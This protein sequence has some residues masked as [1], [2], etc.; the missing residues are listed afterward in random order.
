M[1][2]PSQ[3]RRWVHLSRW[4]TGVIGKECGDS[5]GL[6][7]W[8][9]D[10]CSSSSSCQGSMVNPYGEDSSSLRKALSVGVL[11]LTSSFVWIIISF[12]N[13]FFPF[14]GEDYRTVVSGRYFM[15]LLCTPS[16][17]A[18]WHLW[19]RMKITQ[20]PQKLMGCLKGC[21]H[22]LSQGKSQQVDCG[23]YPWLV[24]SVC[25]RNSLDGGGMRHGQTIRGH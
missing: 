16:H 9:G 1:Q 18:H 8:G 20:G 21:D 19:D 7:P 2:K 12:I 23:R 10:H 22:F 6:L 11:S 15:G 4:Q 13:L 17:L 24:P 5:S 3:E 14:Q 25:P